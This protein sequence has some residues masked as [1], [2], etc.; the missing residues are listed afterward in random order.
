M[1]QDTYA[2]WYNHHPAFDD[3][4]LFLPYSILILYNV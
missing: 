2:Q 3:H 4:Y 1:L